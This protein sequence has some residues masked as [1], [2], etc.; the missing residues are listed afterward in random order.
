MLKGKF[1][2]VREKT[3]VFA[4]EKKFMAHAN[5]KAVLKA[6]ALGLY[7]AELNGVR[8]GDRYLTPGWTSYNKMLQV[9]EY[10]VTELLQEG[11]NVLTFTVGEGWFCSGVTWVKKRDLYGE[12]SAVCADLVF[13]DRAVCTDETWVAHGKAIS[14]Q[15]AFTTAKR[16]ILR[17]R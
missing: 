2:G 5:E 11:E 9:Q 3:G 7:Y 13:A 8:V 10:D 12:Q 14:A 1:I 15:A 4:I 6:T 17:R 16:R